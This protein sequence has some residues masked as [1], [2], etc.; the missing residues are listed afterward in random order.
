MKTPFV[1]AA[2]F[3]AAAISVRASDSSTGAPVLRPF[4]L[5]GNPPPVQM[6]VP[7]FV[8]RELP[9]EL[10]NINNVEYGP[11]GRLYAAGFN[12]K[13][14][15][16]EDTDGD[17]LEDKA[18]VFYESP[19]DVR[20]TVGMVWGADGA[21]YLARRQKVL[22]LRDDG[23][24]TAKAEV[25]ASD[26][27]RPDPNVTSNYL[28]VYGL[29]RDRDGSVYFGLGISDIRNAYRLDPQTKES[30]YSRTW[31]RG[32]IQ[33]VAPDGKREIF[34]TGLRF[35]VALAFNAAGDLFATDQ[36]GATWLPNGNPFD[37]LLHVQRGRHYGFPPR[38]PKYLPDVID[39]PSVF[40][41]RPQHQATCGLHFNEPYS[42]EGLGETSSTPSAP[43]FGPTW[44]RGDALVAGESRGRIYR[45][46]LVKTA[47]GYVAHN[48]TIAHLSM[49]TIDATPTPA[50]DLV[51]CCHSGRPDWGTGPTG[52]G[53]LYK[54]SYR[55]KESPQPIFTGGLRSSSRAEAFSTARDRAGDHDGRIRDRWRSLRVDSPRLPGRE[56]PTEDPSLSAAGAR[57]DFGRRAQ[58]DRTA[59]GATHECGAVFD[60]ASRW[61][62][63]EAGR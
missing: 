16:L 13:V 14:Y 55:D 34:A 10:P 57:D 43:I 62:G 19:D 15:R 24:G 60:R 54:I 45:T 1:L 11:D 6:I 25:I 47:A 7:G 61:P 3:C 39:E 12:G 9:L 29:A 21:L 28:D 17:G 35:T 42:K 63:F 23:N 40:D 59:D 53:K 46:K 56:R 44:W 30:S 51:V 22:R 20:G 50:G 4:A 37:E 41:Y 26:W 18:T 49:L 38:H 33:R 36:E 48:D 2:A 27:M 32:T 58:R 8:V 52:I 5:M 31:D